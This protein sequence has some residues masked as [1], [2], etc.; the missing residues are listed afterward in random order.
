MT[1]TI[2]A[3]VSGT[4][5]A[6]QIN[7]TDV[8]RFGSSTDGQSIGLKNYIINGGCQVAQ[9]GNIAAVKDVWT[10]G[11][12]DR[13]P[14]IV[15]GTTASGTIQQYSGVTTAT[16]Y[17]QGVQATTTGTGSVYIQQ[18]IEAI[19]TKG[20]NGKT[21]TVCCLVYQNTGSDQNCYLRIGKPTTTADTFS[22]QTSLSVS[23]ALSIPSSTPTAIIWTYTLGAAEASLGLFASVEFWNVGDVTA[24]DFWISDF[25]LEKGSIAT[26]FE[27]RPYGL[28]LALCQRYYEKS[29]SGFYA[30]FFNSN[31]TNATT[32]YSG[33]AHYKVTKRA[34]PTVTFTNVGASSFPASVGSTFNSTVDSVSETRT[35][36]ATANSGIFGS[37]FVASAEI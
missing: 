36:N 22:A 31:V 5:G 11:G 18:R 6:I 15:G 4:F 3:D 16:G 1:T 9:R 17:A 7:G 35:S 14:V 8:M 12:C 30:T 25:Q 32:Y 34:V 27:V 23:G 29:T 37:S 21:I 20:L 10:Y 19:N 26:P 33:I 2:R 28:E 24:K 13:T